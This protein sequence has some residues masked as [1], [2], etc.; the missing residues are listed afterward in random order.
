MS[1]SVSAGLLKNPSELALLRMATSPVSPGGRIS[2]SEN[3]E[4]VHIRER[5]T[6]GNPSTGVDPVGSPDFRMLTLTVASARPLRPS[7]F[8]I[9]KLVQILER[10]ILSHLRSDVDETSARWNVEPKVFSIGFQD[11]LS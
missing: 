1:F 2:P 11:Y 5:S 7:H 8:L 3:D 10:W 6:N 4:Q 9:Q